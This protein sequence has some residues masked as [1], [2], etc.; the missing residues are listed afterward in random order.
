MLN[1]DSTPKALWKY[2]IGA[3]VK[4]VDVDGG[5]Q[6]GR[7]RRFDLIG[8]VLY[9]E[10]VDYFHPEEVSMI[11]VSELSYNPTRAERGEL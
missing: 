11:P 7:I 3:R 4:W 6:M 9:A 1:D 10:I 5:H 2:V 8:D